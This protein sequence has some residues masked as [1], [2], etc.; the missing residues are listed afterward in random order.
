MCY[1]VSNLYSIP[2]INFSSFVGEIPVVCFIYKYIYKFYLL[3]DGP[4][5]KAKTCNQQ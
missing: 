4:I 5:T 1:I 3:D 2:H